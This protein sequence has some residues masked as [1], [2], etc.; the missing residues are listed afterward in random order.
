VFAL[1]PLALAAAGL[2]A[3]VGPTTATVTL[4]GWKSAGAVGAAFA[5]ITIMIA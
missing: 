1:R 3:C 4:M 2:L 5:D